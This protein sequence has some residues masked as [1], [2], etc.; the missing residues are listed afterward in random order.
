MKLKILFTTLLIILTITCVSAATITVDANNNRNGNNSSFSSIQEAINSA[1]E[2]D[3]ILIHKGNYLETLTVDKQLKISS[4]SHKPEDVIINSGMLSQPIIHVTSN[5]VEITGL[6]IHGN[7][8]EKQT[9]GICLDNVRNSLIQNNVISNFQDGIFLNV[10][11]ANIIEN[12][13]ILSNNLHGIYLISSTSNDLK[14]NLI[15]DNKHGLYLKFSNRNILADNNASSNEKY[16]I[17]LLDSN[18]NNL[19]NNQIL[20]NKYGLCLTESHENTITHNIASNNNQSGFLLFWESNYNNVDG[21]VLKGNEN[22]GIYIISCSNNTFNNNNLSNNTNGISIETTN[23]NLFINNTFSSNKEYGMFYPYSSSNNIIKENI[24]SK[25]KKGDDNLSSRPIYIIL[26]LLTGISFAY[27]LKK[28]SL[29]KKALVG[30]SILI[31]ISLIAIVAWYYP[32]EAEIPGNNIEISNLSWYN[33][34]MINETHTQV[35]LSM[36]INYSYKKAY[37]NHFDENSQTDIIPTTVQVSSTKYTPNV[38]VDT[39]DTGTPY[40]LLSEK[41]INLTYRKPFKYKTILDLKN[42]MKHDIQISVIYKKE[43]DYPNANGE[44]SRWIQLGA[45]QQLISI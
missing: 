15:T 4:I 18:T 20:M 2:N 44:E 11:S 26:I 24:F 3:S 38:V 32:F 29:L 8:N 17:A 36:D 9:F 13:T 33:S 21:N 41:K 23:N 1:K 34:S 6:T 43:Y 12:N 27:Y 40:T 28:R 39:G 37:D 16:G 42:N 22:S 30:L 7:N 31:I 45:G 14:N 5:N 19:T 25:N 35:I 10:S